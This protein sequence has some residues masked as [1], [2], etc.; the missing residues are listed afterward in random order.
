[1]SPLGNDRG[2]VRWRRLAIVGTVLALSTICLAQPVLSGGA[3][4][5]IAIA[6]PF[7]HPLAQA[8]ERDSREVVEHLKV[9]ARAGSLDAQN[10]LGLCYMEGAGMSFARPRAG[11]R[12]FMLA[13]QAGHAPAMLNLAKAYLNG[14]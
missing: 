12:L 2:R 5:D 1:F 7:G 9:A 10:E 11:L 13:A 4:G 3:G 6:L 8:A 14:T